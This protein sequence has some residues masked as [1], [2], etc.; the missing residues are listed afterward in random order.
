MTEAILILSATNTLAAIVA[1]WQRH[2]SATLARE[3]RLKRLEK[4]RRQRA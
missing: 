2:Q 4:A 3:K 1:L